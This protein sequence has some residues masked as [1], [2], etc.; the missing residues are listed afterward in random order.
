[1]VVVSLVDDNSDSFL[2]GF[3]VCRVNVSIDC[4]LADLWVGWVMVFDGEFDPG[5]GRTLAVR[6][7]HASRTVNGASAPGSVANGCV[8]RG[9]PAPDPGITPGNRS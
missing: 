3:V 9:Q 2:S 6:L 7:I 4:G 1:M 5:S 8:T